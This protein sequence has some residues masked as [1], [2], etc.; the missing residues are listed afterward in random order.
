MRNF[1]FNIC[2]AKKD[3]NVDNLAWN[4]IK[5]IKQEVGNKAVIMG[6]SGGVDST[7][8]AAL[9]HKAIGKRL[10]C[11]FVDHGLIRKNEGTLIV[12]KKV[13]FY[14]HQKC[15]NFFKFIL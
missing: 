11:V 4:L 3:W 2:K 14:T 6:T 5:G 8:A 12:L 15:F 7:V 13:T 10:Y 1:V 9:I